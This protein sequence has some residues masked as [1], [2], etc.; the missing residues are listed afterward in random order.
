ML[1][2]SIYYNISITN[3]NVYTSLR[4]YIY[5]YICIHIFLYTAREGQQAAS[6][7]GWDPRAEPSRAAPG[8]R[9]HRPRSPLLSLS[10]RGNVVI[11]S[12]VSYE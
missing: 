12:I 11:R 2:Y 10:M 8:G 9:G 7:K 4:I 6:Q 1:D 3:N 5:I